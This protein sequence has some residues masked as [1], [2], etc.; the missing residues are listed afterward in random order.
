MSHGTWH[1]HSCFA[2]R[3][4]AV[5]FMFIVRGHG[6]KRSGAHALFQQ[7]LR[8][9]FCMELVDS[10]RHHLPF[11]WTAESQVSVVK[12]HVL[13]HQGLWSGTLSPGN[14]W[15]E[16]QRHTQSLEAHPSWYTGTHTHRPISNPLPHT[17]TQTDRHR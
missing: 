7:P 15:K 8:M 5:R 1:S 14:T 12:A 2:R 3:P 13:R 16:F 17:H 6:S 4:W 10:G 11:C 9:K